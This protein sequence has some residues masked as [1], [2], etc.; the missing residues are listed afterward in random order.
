LRAAAGV[1]GKV[2]DRLLEF[3]LGHPVGLG[4]AE[5][6]TKLFG[7]PVGDQRSARDQ[8]AVSRS[9]LG[10]GPHVA[11]QDVIGELDKFRGE[12]TDELLRARRLL[13]RS[14]V[15]SCRHGRFPFGW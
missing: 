9:Q 8:A 12:V 10:S 11:E 1:E 3:R 7:A 13:G 2:D 6:G 14:A 15:L 4:E 5:V